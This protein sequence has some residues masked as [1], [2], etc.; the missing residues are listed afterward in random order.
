MVKTK[1]PAWS[2]FKASGDESK[3]WKD[4][5]EGELHKGNITKLKLWLSFDSK[6]FRQQHATARLALLCTL[7]K[8]NMDGRAQKLKNEGAKA[9]AARARAAEQ[10][11]VGGSGQA[12]ASSAGAGA[13]LVEP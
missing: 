9:K 5:Y 10:R 2:H 7:K 8:G 6:L 12:N 3:P 1:D 11:G 13:S 4:L